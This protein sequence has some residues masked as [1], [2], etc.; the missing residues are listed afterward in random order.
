MN[1]QKVVEVLKCLRGTPETAPTGLIQELVSEAFSGEPTS[2]PGAATEV[3]LIVDQIVESKP[4]RA[5]IDAMLG[6]VRNHLSR[7]TEP[8][9]LAVLHRCV[10]RLRDL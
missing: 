8:E 3:Q 9:K 6:M 7:A 10:C 4:D 1:E 5:E 2:Q